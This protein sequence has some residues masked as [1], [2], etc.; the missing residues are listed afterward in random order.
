[1][2]ANGNGNGS[3]P[4]KGPMLQNHDNNRG[5]SQAYLIRNTAAFQVLALNEV[6]DDNTL[7]AKVTRARALRD[8]TAVWDN[9]SERIRIIRGRP[10]PGSLKPKEPKRKRKVQTGPL[11]TDDSASSASPDVSPQP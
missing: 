3:T 6:P 7:E 9:A 8:L 10:L 1:M 2:D 4:V 11:F 5:L